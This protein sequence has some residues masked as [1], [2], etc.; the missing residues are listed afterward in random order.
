MSTG[1]PSPVDDLSAFT[2]RLDGL[3][4]DQTPDDLSHALRNALDRHALYSRYIFS[5]VGDVERAKALLEIFDKVRTVTYAISG[6]ILRPNV[7]CRPLK[8]LNPMIRSSS[9]F[10]NFVVGRDFYLHPTPFQK[11]SSNNRLSNPSP[12]ALLA[13]FGKAS[14]TAN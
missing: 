10:G 4:A 7:R 13:T 6:S 11:N 5:L 1:V 14:M 2:A 9:S 12:L 8:L 3:H